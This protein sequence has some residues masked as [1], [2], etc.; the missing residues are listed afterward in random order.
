MLNY[1]HIQFDELPIIGISPNE[2][3]MELF[4][5]IK[6]FLHDKPPKIKTIVSRYINKKTE[7]YNIEAYIINS[8]LYNKFIPGIFPN[9]IPLY[10]RTC[11]IK[12]LIDLII[13]FKNHVLLPITFFGTLA[14]LP[15][16]YQYIKIPGKQLKIYNIEQKKLVEIDRL[17]YISYINICDPTY[18]NIN[19]LHVFTI[20][21]FNDTGISYV[22]YSSI[23]ENQNRKNNML[24]KVSNCYTSAY[25][26]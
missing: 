10:I 22:F 8:S 1:L 16:N 13:C 4:K 21:T 11:N 2:S 12:Q 19:D 15:D 7:Y 26:I 3:Y 23:N 24:K 14:L 18:S 5:Q 25:T 20:S 17:D 9:D 6:N